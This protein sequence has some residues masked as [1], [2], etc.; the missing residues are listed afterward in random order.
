[1]VENVPLRL[2]KGREKAAKLANGFL[3]DL[4]GSDNRLEWKEE[5]IFLSFESK[6][7]KRTAPPLPLA[8]PH[9]AR[10]TDAAER[11]L[12][13]TTT[14]IELLYRMNDGPAIHTS[15]TNRALVIM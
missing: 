14:R 2:I 3:I 1:M 8:A 6:L 9:A 7:D 5:T 4:K 12:H 10:A 11:G 13:A 15:G